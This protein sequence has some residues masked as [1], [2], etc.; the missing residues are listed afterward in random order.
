[1]KEKLKKNGFSLV[2]TLIYVAILA[3]I[4]TVIINMLLSFTSTYKTVVALRVA[5]HSAI[6]AM[7]RMTREIRSSNSVD[8]G[9]S[10][11]GISP[12]VLTLQTYSGALS[13]TTKFY[14]SSGVLKMDVNGAYFGPLTLSNATVNSLVFRLLDNGF[15][16]AVKID[17]SITGTVGAVTKTKTYHSTVILRGK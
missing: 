6:D 17:L 2:E 11:L 4:S 13:T 8:T 15:S 16:Q 5:E 14:V 12:G 1:M 10:T 7:E 9:N 3:V